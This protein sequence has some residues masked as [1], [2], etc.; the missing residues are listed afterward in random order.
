[1]KMQH[2]V[3][4]AACKKHHPKD[5]QALSPAVFIFLIQQP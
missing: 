5:V 2:Q 4:L 3:M 1:M